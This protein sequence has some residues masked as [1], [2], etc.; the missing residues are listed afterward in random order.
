[1]HKNVHL[2]EKKRRSAGATEIMRRRSPVVAFTRCAFFFFLRSFP[3]RPTRTRAHSTTPHHHHRSVDTEPR[4]AH[5]PPP[6]KTP[7]RI[8]TVEDAGVDAALSRGLS[9]TLDVAARRNIAPPRSTASR[10]PLLAAFSFPRRHACTE[11]VGAPRRG[12]Y[13][14]AAAHTCC[15]PE[16]TGEQRGGGTRG[17]PRGKPTV[18]ARTLTRKPCP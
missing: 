3:S 6:P 12:I 13:P 8:Q 15:G 17:G 4:R 2:Q 11:P 16:A 18:R 10:D 14:D 1:M 5:L 9:G 7:Q